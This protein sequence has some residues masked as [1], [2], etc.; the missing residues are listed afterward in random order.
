MVTCMDEQIGNIVQALQNKQVLDNTLIFFSSDN[1]GS[2]N[3][4]A[5]NGPLRKGKGSP[6]EGGI[7]VPAFINWPNSLKGGRTFD[8]PVHIVDLYPTLTQLAGGSTEKCLP[9]DGIDVW[10]AIADGTDL[11]KR[12]I[13]HNVKDASGR[14]S[15]R[16]G[17]WK[18]VLSKPKKAPHA[19]PLEGSNLVAEL[20]NI[21]EDPYEKNDVAAQYPELI[22]TLWTK[23]KQHGPEIGDAKPYI[24]RA[25][26][27]W[28][29]PA[30]WSKTPE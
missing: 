7:R 20:F 3:S 25:P 8:Q 29:A 23:L 22:D 27:G 4:G 26:E 19:L 11:P 10:P 14:G 15:I 18:L 28:V 24:A 13:L 1:G 16:S 17:D 5:S 9:L 12:D 21:R 6:Y 2:L 30:D